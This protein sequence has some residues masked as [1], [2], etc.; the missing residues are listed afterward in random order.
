MARLVE[1][2]HLTMSAKT[3][4]GS[5]SE[6]TGRPAEDVTTGV[7]DRQVGEF[8]RAR[9]R[10]DSNDDDHDDAGART[11]DDADADDADADDADDADASGA[12]AGLAARPTHLARRR[13]GAERGLVLHA[14]RPARVRRARDPLR[15]DDAVGQHVMMRL[16]DDRVLVKT[17]T[18]FRTIARVLLARGE[19]RELVAFGAAD[20]H[21]HAVL[22]CSRAVAGLFAQAVEAALRVVLGLPVPFAPARFRPVLDQHHLMSSSAYSVR[23]MQRHGLALDPLRDGT[24]LPDLLGLRVLDPT[25]AA[26]FATRLPRVTRDDLLAL[27]GV[28]LVPG[29]IDLSPLADAAAAALALPDLDGQDADRMNARRAAVHV[30]LA[31]GLRHA[32]IGELLTTTVRTVQRL[33]DGPPH[34]PLVRAVCLQLRLGAGLARRLL[35][36]R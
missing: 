12:D 8:R 19:R 26:R 23:Q 4:E 16:V 34:L 18:D 25:L 17:P 7:V 32:R 31:A 35:A 2:A 21:I 9:R 3:R 28:A 5:V 29:P 13:D 24:S 11:V 36:P 1:Q 27:L 6:V 14:D 20:N 22:T 30:G 10:A 15:V 33:A